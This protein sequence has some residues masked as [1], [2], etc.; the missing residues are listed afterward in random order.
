MHKEE[1]DPLVKKIVKDSIKPVV[2]V[3]VRDIA[4]Q[5]KSQT[6]IEPSTSE[7]WYS[8]GRLGLKSR[9]AWK[10]KKEHE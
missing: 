8:L 5:V 2:T 6:G 4:E 7:V 1:L 10:H 3:S 9:W